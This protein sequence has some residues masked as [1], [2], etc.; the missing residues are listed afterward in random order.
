MNQ[1]QI[2]L[3]DPPWSYRVWSGK[4]KSRTAENHY[5]SEAHKGRL[6]QTGSVYHAGVA[7]G[8]KNPGIGNHPPN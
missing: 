3:A 6:H 2:I 1:Y 4:E 8:A 7:A 5:P